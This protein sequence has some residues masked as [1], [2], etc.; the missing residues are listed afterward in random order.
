MK[1]LA[2]ILSAR[3]PDA[4]YY[5]AHPKGKRPPTDMGVYLNRTIVWV[6]D[7]AALRAD[8]HPLVLFMLQNAGE[9]EPAPAG[10]W[11]AVGKA[12]RDKDWWWAF[13]LPPA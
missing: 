11:T 10:E 2:D 8:R 5:N 3:Y 4:L 7:A 12:R 13:V 1:Q 9:P 6:P